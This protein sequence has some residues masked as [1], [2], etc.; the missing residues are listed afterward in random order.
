MRKKKSGFTLIELMIS[1]GILS[2]IL[3]LVYSFF[4][5]SQKNMS[6]TQVKSDLQLQAQG[7]LDYVSKKGMQAQSI[8]SITGA[9][10]S[11]NLTT[12][13]PDTLVKEI[14]FLNDTESY[15]FNL[16]NF[17]S[18]NN[19]YDLNYTEQPSASTKKIGQYVK[20]IKISIING[21][22][23]TNYGNCSAL[24]VTIDLSKK[25]ANNETFDYSVTT[26]VYFRNRN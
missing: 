1:L 20:D 7:I 11:I 10:G 15:S 23:S 3:A 25:G 9:A 24:K 12:S 4:L 8:N 16:T 2:I 5:S 22:A 21:D 14:R 6:R 13:A 18:E 26:N 19:T 17:D